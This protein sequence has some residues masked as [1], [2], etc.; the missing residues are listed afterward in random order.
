M[1]PGLGP[2]P[3]PWASCCTFTALTVE[4]SLQRS[5]NRSPL[6]RA[7]LGGCCEMRP[8]WAEVPSAGGRSRSRW[9][10]S[11]A[12]LGRLC[13][14]L[15]RPRR[16]EPPG[17]RRWPAKTRPGE[18]GAA[19]PFSSPASLWRCHFPILSIIFTSSLS[20]CPCPPFITLLL[21]LSLFHHSHYP[22]PLSIVL[23]PSLVPPC[24][25]HSISLSLSI[26]SF[27]PPSTLILTLFPLRHSPAVPVDPPSL[28]PHPCR[29][30]S[31]SQ[32]PL[33]RISFLGSFWLCPPGPALLPLSLA[34][35]SCQQ[36]SLG[37]AQRT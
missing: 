13:S 10:S 3:P 6:P 26:L 33:S 16:G 30:P 12:A 17:S 8:G 36:A 4:N 18:L 14:A 19:A 11:S 9:Q 34:V 15:L 37:R 1:S 5:R 25:S 7:L 31:L 32:Q 2:L 22:Y 35:A 28:S 29:L 27:L 21:S 20:Y 24:H 23:A